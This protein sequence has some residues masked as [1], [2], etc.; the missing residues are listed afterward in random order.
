MDELT[1]TRC[2]ADVLRRQL[3]P[4]FIVSDQEHYRK[5]CEYSAKVDL[6]I[7]HGDKM[8]IYVE[9]NQNQEINLL[10]SEYKISAC[11]IAWRH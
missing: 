3:P 1:R 4:S 6:E 5:F 2:F 11:N 9:E 8:L 10:V 7:I